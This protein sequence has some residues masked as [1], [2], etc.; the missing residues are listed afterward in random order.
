MSDRYQSDAFDTQQ[1]DFPRDHRPHD[2][3][4]RREHPPL[5]A[6]LARC[7]LRPDEQVTWVVGPRFNPPWEQYVTHPALAGVAVVV[8]VLC[9]LTGRMTVGSWSELPVWPPVVAGALFFASIVVLGV[10]C[11][12]FTRLVVTNQR[13]LLTQ[14][15][16]IYRKWNIDDLPRSL[17]RYGRRERGERSEP[18]IDLDA[19]QT[20]LGSASDQFAEAKTILAFGKQL[21]HIKASE[22]RR[23]DERPM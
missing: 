9:V 10:C 16:E 2:V 21:G 11:G 4:R 19:L 18:T 6:F 13:L 15:R 3:P 22:D 5:P 23:P 12:Y 17:L 1:P 7:W 8:G 14:G 20:M